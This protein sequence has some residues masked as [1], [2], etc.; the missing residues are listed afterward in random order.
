[1]IMIRLFLS[2]TVTL[3]LA[4]T[5]CASP[6]QAAKAKTVKSEGMLPWTD[7][8]ATTKQGAL[9]DAL[10]K[11]ITATLQEFV[12]EGKLLE[13][14]EYLEERIYPRVLRYVLSY[15]ITSKGWLV[16]YDMPG[17]LDRGSIKFMEDEAIEGSFSALEEL[18][19][20]GDLSLDVEEYM[21]EEVEEDPSFIRG[22][23]A[24]G[25]GV[26]VYHV[27]IETKVDEEQL[28]RDVKGAL[29]VT[30]ERTR[31]LEIV[32]LGVKEF[33][34]FESFKVKLKETE[35]L[36][37]LEYKSF[38]PGRV[39]MKAKVVASADIF[40]RELTVVLGEGFTVLQ[41]GMGDTVLVNQL[42]GKK[43]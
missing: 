11:V 31:E 37:G 39:T 25:G 12:P 35:L 41:A 40:V 23:A 6:A 33:K 15:K 29:G 5:L 27:W 38:S 43:R 17:L 14:K 9:D 16:H 22:I 4:T 20:E 18:G 2:I 1:M 24:H 19:A 30:Q 8:E 10:K 3:V 34:E 36:S 42:G 21:T 26:N 13:H 28:K 7:N 32:L